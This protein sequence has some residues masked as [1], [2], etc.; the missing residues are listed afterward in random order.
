[1]K[2]RL[3]LIAFFALLLAGALAFAQAKPEPSPSPQPAQ[4]AQAAPQPESP[5]QQLVEASKGAEQGKEEGDEEAQFK[6]SPS[7]QWLG[8]HLGMNKEAAY[9]LFLG[10]NFAVVAGFILYAFKKYAP[11]AFRDRTALIKR[12]LEEAR[13]ASEEANRRLSEIEARLAR[14]NGEIAEMRS[15]AEKD[16]ANE[17][18]R[19]KAAAEDDKKKIIST[20]E[21]EI[22]S[23]AKLARGELK[24]FAAELAVALAE[25]KIDVTPQTDQA[26]V[27]QFTDRLSDGGKR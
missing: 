18:Q 4:P 3:P 15:G 24:K 14:L 13:A 20:A 11:S 27:K 22:T 21:Q 19:L 2:S 8:R 17:E 9:W 5:Q 6:Y 25:K 23:A 10:L 26:L 7:V 16:S 12:Q 1:L